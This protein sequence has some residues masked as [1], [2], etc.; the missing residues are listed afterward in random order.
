MHQLATNTKEQN[1]LYDLMGNLRFTIGVKT[2]IPEKHTEKEIKDHIVELEKAYA[3]SLLAIKER[4]EIIK[5]T[6][7]YQKKGRK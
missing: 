7:Q 4:M 6:R 5:L 1:K 2:N 3:Q